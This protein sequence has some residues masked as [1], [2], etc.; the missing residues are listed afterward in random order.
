MEVKKFCVNCEEFSNCGVIEELGKEIVN[1]TTRKTE[2][3]DVCIKHCLN[4]KCN[5]KAF[6]LESVV[7]EGVLDSCCVKYGMNNASCNKPMVRD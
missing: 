5:T 6:N 1:G 4:C 7:K 2:L 3:A